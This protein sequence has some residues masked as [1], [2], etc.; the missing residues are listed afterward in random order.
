[1]HTHVRRCVMG[2]TG[3]THNTIGA[4]N[5]STKKMRK[6][7]QRKPTDK[8]EGKRNINIQKGFRGGYVRR[9]RRSDAPGQPHPHQKKLLPSNPASGLKP[10]PRLKQPLC[11]PWAGSLSTKPLRLCQLV[12]HTSIN[13]P[14]LQAT[15]GK[16]L[17]RPF[18]SN[19]LFIVEG[20]TLV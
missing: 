15:L 16:N 6:H 5:K 13:N 2:I 3:K 17:R 12:R 18:T 10:P 4:N 19:R 9:E 11:T 14:R 8:A 1:M 7:N 20:V